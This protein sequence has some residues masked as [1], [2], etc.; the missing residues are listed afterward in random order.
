MK[1]ID[2]EDVDYQ[3]IHDTYSTCKYIERQGVS[4]EKYSLG[5]CHDEIE[6]ATDE[7]NLPIIQVIN[8]D[9]IIEGYIIN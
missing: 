4:L 8:P 1:T 2:I 5:N 9:G 7:L 3:T 6:D